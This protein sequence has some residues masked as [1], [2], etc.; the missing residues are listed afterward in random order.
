[1]LVIACRW[2][3]LFCSDFI[4]LAVP[5]LRHPPTHPPSQT[6]TS[7][8][9]V[10]SHGLNMWAGGALLILWA[11]VLIT[12]VTLAARL[13]NPPLPLQWFAAFFRTGSVIYGGGQVVLPMLYYDVVKE[14]CTNGVCTEAPGSWMTSKQFYAGLGVVQALPGPLFNFSAY[15]G[16]IIATNAGYNFMVGAVLCWFGLFGPGIMIIFGIMPFWGW[17]RNWSVYRFALPGLNA[18]GIGL[19]VASVFSL[20]L[21]VLNTTTHTITAMCIGFIAFTAVDQFKWFEPAVVVAGGIMGIIAWA[22]GMR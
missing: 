10:K 21:G 12:V 14:T 7:D 20:A 5:G 16:A 3:G 4:V 19:I 13:E 22:A 2:A 8:S 6:Q 17:F 9:S 18:A 1:M 15:L 11:A